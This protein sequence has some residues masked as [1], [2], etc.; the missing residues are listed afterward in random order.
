MK[1][2]T[3]DAIDDALAED[4]KASFWSRYR[5]SIHFKSDLKEVFFRPHKRYATL[6]GA[7][8]ITILLLVLFHV[9]YGVVKILDENLSAFFEAF[10]KYLNWM[11]QTQGSDP[12]FVV[13]G[14]LVSYTLFREYDRAQSLDIMRYFKRRMLRIYPLFLVGLLVFLPSNAR[15]WDYLLSNLV[16][17]SN[18]LPNDRPI[19]PVAW[20]LEV[21]VQFYILLPFLC[22]LLYKVRWRI[23]L[24]VSL[25]VATLAYRYW[26][27]ASNPVYYETPLYQVHYNRAFARLMADKLYYDFDVRAGGFFMGMLVAYLHHYYGKVMTDFFK[28]HPVVNTLL[29]FTALYLIAWSF[30]YPMFNPEADFYTNFDANANLWYLAL[31]R[32]TYSLGMSILLI[33]VLCPAGLSRIANWVMSWPIWHPFAQMIYPIYLF[34]FPFIVLGMVVS[35]GTIDEDSITS[36]SMPE[37]FSIYFFT[38]LFTII[39]SSLVHIFIERP[40]LKFREA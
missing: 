39:F 4:K 24:L 34:H 1:I 12:L 26:V 37:V 20:S 30:S 40:F 2:G 15:Y 11:W 10:P 33:M 6:D 32:Y 3:T 9:L 27:V 8:A 35:F 16:F 38:L 36:V 28:R 13:S 17:I 14:L 22:L 18:Y 5:Q 23:P 21:Q 31:N 29:L 25:I 7:R 19:I